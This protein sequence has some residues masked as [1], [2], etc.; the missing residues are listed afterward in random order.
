ME[1]V[2][3]LSLS[4]A[5]ISFLYL[6]VSGVFILIIYFPLQYLASRRRGRIARIQRL[7]AA[8]GVMGFVIVAYYFLESVFGRMEPMQTIAFMCGMLTGSITVAYLIRFPM[9]RNRIISIFYLGWVAMLV[10]FLFSPMYDAFLRWTRFGG[11]IEVTITRPTSEPLRGNLFLMTAQK[12]MLLMNNKFVEIPVDQATEIEYAAFPKW[13]L[14]DP[15][16]REQLKYLPTR[17]F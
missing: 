17:S 4:V 11:G 2:P 16:L 1:G 10:G 6:L 12:V 14:P 15:Q 5:I 7:L 8:F 3:F 13:Y 9:Y